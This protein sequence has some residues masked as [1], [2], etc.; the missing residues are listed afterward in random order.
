[1]FAHATL[2]SASRACVAERK[3]INQSSD[4]S[5]SPTASAFIKKEGGHLLQNSVMNG[6]FAT[7]VLE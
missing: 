3:T 7:F 6:V 1:M 2:N 4:R 5:V